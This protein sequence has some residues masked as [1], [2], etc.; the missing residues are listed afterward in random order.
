M[1]RTRWIILALYLVALA[2]SHLTQRFTAHPIEPHPWAA[3]LPPMTAEGTAHAHANTPRVTLNYVINPGRATDIDEAPVL[4]IHGSPGSGDNFGLL[5]PRLNYSGYTTITVDLPGFGDSTPSIPDYSVRAHARYCLAL[6]DR[7]G[8]E[9]FHAVGWSM[10]GGVC[11]E[12][13]RL[14]RDKANPDQPAR[15]ASV[16]LLGALGAMETEGSGSYTFEKAKYTAGYAALVAL[17]EVVPHFGLLGP[18]PLRHSFVRNFLDTDQRP[19]AQ[20]MRTTTVPYLVLHGRNDF[21]ISDWAAERHH[22]FIPTSRLV[23]TPF[24][25][26]LPVAQADETSDF[27]ND[28]IDRHD[29][30]GVRPLTHT[31]NHAPVPVRTGALGLLDSIAV[32]ARDWP[33]W[34]VVPIGALCARFRPKLTTALLA[35]LC[36]RL[37]LDFGVATVAIF[38]GRRLTP[39]TPWQRPGRGPLSKAT[40]VRTTTDLAWTPIALAL[41]QAAFSTDVADAAGGLGFVGLVIA[42]T[43][44]LNILRALPT[45]TGRIRLRTNA[46]KWFHHEWWPMWLLYAGL[47][48]HLI[49]LGSRHKSCLVWTAANPGVPPDEGIQGESKSALLDRIDHPSV[50]P[51][52]VVPPGPIANRVSRAHELIESDADLGGF[53]II[54]KPDAGERGKDVALARAADDLERALALIAGPAMLQRF[55]PGPIEAGVFWIRHL[56]T[57]GR[58]TEVDAENKAHGFIFAITRKTLPEVTGD[59]VRTLRQLVVRHPRYRKQ[60]AVYAGRAD[61]DTRVPALDETVRLTEAGNHARGCMFSDGDDLRTPELE[62]VIDRIASAYQSPEGHRYDFGRFDVRAES[63]ADLKAGR[64]AVIELNGTTSES[65]NLYDPKRST[66]WAYGVLREQWSYLFELGSARA[67]QGSEVITWGELLRLTFSLFTGR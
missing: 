33:W 17:P 29:T 32:A 28:F 61:F 22:E 25:H 64:F 43:L 15:L 59:G 13:D 52:A 6:L 20:A 19:L 14:T 44:G 50:L 66:R 58:E 51:Y 48:P 35:Y 53:P 5:I 7:L 10:G 1:T 46:S 60:I 3:A 30:P 26:F 9:R 55:H 45:R 42:V 47:L 36:A 56:E 16:T 31:A 24:S 27:I 65:T 18:R 57:V 8:I 63:E 2:A 67:N 41:A 12:L 62:T 4:L 39:P 49:R 21:L 23:M 11:I 54:V 38:L 40:L 34:L 37:S